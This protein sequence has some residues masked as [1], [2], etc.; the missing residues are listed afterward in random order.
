MISRIAVAAG[1]VGLLSVGCS[2]NADVGG[3]ESIGE[4]RA[5]I[6]TATPFATANDVVNLANANIG[7]MAC[8]TNSLGGHSFESS[9]TGNGGQPEYWCAD[10][11]QWVWANSGVDTAGL[12]AAAGSFYV[13]G[14]NHGTLSNTPA[15]GDAV[16][17]DYQGGGVADHVAIVT[18]VNSDGTIE[19]LSGDWNGQSGSEATFASTSH[20]VLN[21]P[22]YPSAVGGAPAVIGMTIS[23]YIA[24]VGLTMPYGAGFVGQSFPY[25]STALTMTAGETL[26]SWIEM[27]NTGG[28]TWDSN[29]KLAT[30]SP[31]DRASVF[32]DSSWL[33]PNRLAAVSGTVAPGGSYKFTFNLHAPDK[34]G[35]YFE[36]FDLVQESVAWFS[37]PGQGG[38]PDNQLE[39]QVVVVAA[40]ASDGGT[41]HAP[42]AGAAGGSDA[43]IGVGT[44]DA[45]G[46]KRPPPAAAPGATPGNGNGDP[47]PPGEGASAA[48]GTG[49]SATPQSSSPWTGGALVSL[50]LALV[51]FRTKRRAR[52][53]R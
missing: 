11:V 45:G 20:V 53:A 47:N 24:P 9:C 28:Q 31:R 2:G 51:A 42:D 25:A 4:S 27:K 10:F 6:T 12:D 14:Q 35:T 16:V 37:D 5:A 41:A 17:F 8:A 33:S 1:A 22:A 3:V 40:P 44:E 52:P 49:C 39:V 50:G 15:I 34:P 46:A 36:Y 32:A 26:A 13:Y 23:G 43:G 30:S 38:P 18:K 29:T 19:S 48:D 7:G 21:A